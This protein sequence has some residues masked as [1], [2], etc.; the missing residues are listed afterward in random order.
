MLVNIN[1]NRLIQMPSLKWRIA[2][3]GVLVILEETLE[4]YVSKNVWTL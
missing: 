2:L 3:T 4:E 1:H